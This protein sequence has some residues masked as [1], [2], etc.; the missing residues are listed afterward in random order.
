[1]SS[2]H[3]CTLAPGQARV[4]ADTSRLPAEVVPQDSG[5]D[6]MPSLAALALAMCLLPE[7]AGRLSEGP[8]RRRGASETNPGG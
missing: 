2:L 8:T 5:P 7:H 1:M 4:A 6:A 3:R